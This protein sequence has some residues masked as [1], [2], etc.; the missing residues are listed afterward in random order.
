MSLISTSNGKVSYINIENA[1]PANALIG[2][3]TKKR[4]QPFDGHLLLRNDVET[5]GTCKNKKTKYVKERAYNQQLFDKKL[6]KTTPF[7]NVLNSDDFINNFQ[8]SLCEQAKL[9]TNSTTFLNFPNETK[10]YIRS[11]I[12]TISENKNLNTEEQHAELGVLHFYLTS[13]QVLPDSNFVQ[14]RTDELINEVNELKSLHKEHCPSSLQAQFPTG[15]RAYLLRAFVR[16]I[17]PADGEFNPGGCKALK[18]MMESP[19]QLHI[20]EEMRMQVIRIA[21]R[22]LA[23]ESFV[24][25]F[26]EPFEVH[27]DLKELISIDLQLPLDEPLNSIYVRWA[28]LIAL[29]A[30]LSQLIDERNCF[31][32]APTANLLVNRPDN[33]IKILTTVLKTG[34]LEFEN[35]LFPIFRLLEGA[36]ANEDEFLENVR[37]KDISHLTPFFMLRACLNIP[38][39]RWKNNKEMTLNSSMA[40]Q[41]KGDVDYAKQLYLSL[42]QN[43]LQ[44]LLVAIVQFAAINIQNDPKLEILENGASTKEEFIY[45]LIRRIKLFIYREKGVDIKN[46]PNLERHLQKLRSALSQSFYLVDY[47]NWDMK[48]DNGIVSFDHHEKGLLLVYDMEEYD[49]FMEQRRLFFFDNEKLIPVDTIT[50]FKEYIGEVISKVA[51]Q[52]RTRNYDLENEYVSDFI[53]WEKFEESMSKM[54][55]TLNMS[56]VA[57]EADSYQDSD[58]FIIGQDGSTTHFLELWKPLSSY[59]S[60][61]RLKAKNVSS[62]FFQLCKVFSNYAKGDSDLYDMNPWIL[63]DKST[64]LFNFYPFRFKEYWNEKTITK[65]QRNMLESLTIDRVEEKDTFTTEKKARIIDEV[66]ESASTRA[67][68]SLINSSFNTQDFAAEAKIILPEDVHSKLDDVINRVMSE[69]EV[70]EVIAKLKEILSYLGDA[71]AKAL[72]YKQVLAKIQDGFEIYPYITPYQLAKIIHKVLILS[73]DPIAVSKDGLEKHIRKI[74]NMPEIIDIG[75][76]NWTSSLEEKPDFYYLSIKYDFVYGLVFC[77]RQNEVVELLSAKETIN[78]LDE[79]ILYMPK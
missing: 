8:S 71:A 29:I 41:F 70:D 18:K 49:C 26:R 69:I 47:K 67:I 20:T 73:K 68:S 76:L 9:I 15:V 14:F 32:I 31:T 54:L 37:V 24:E 38:D 39:S 61:V 51:Q 13:K 43:L 6:I 5:N 79:T 62:F 30:P 63:A 66:L 60:P 59:L 75:N 44:K 7:Y 42:K 45:L 35:K 12:L 46:S 64:H 40:L 11:L 25:I 72:Y 4:R 3:P 78:I 34:K 22:L 50:K 55:V 53:G 23:D 27:D 2:S 1:Q 56:E 33:A 57:L 28:L 74:F 36:R 77:K 21:D 65:D 52:A 17:F 58:S 19:L 48:I 10:Q 16:M